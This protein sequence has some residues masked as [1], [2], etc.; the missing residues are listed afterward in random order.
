[1][2]S[3][4]QESRGLR[5]LEDFDISFVFAAG[6]GVA[7]EDFGIF[8][9]ANRNGEESDRDSMFDVFWSVVFDNQMKVLIKK[10]F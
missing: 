8:A 1:M 3:S 7:A 4:E 2:R 6:V 5:G 9:A 10:A